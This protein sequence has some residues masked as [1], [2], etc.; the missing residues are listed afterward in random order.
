MFVLTL[1]NKTIIMTT[2]ENYTTVQNDLVDIQRANDRMDA[3][4]MYDMD[5]IMSNIRNMEA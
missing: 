2:V 5:F 3:D 4:W 1:T